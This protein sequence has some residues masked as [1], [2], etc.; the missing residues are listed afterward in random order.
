MGAKPPT[1]VL[2]SF[3]WCLT[4]D[5]N[6]VSLPASPCR[7]VSTRV[8]ISSKKPERIARAF[9]WALVLRGVVVITPSML[10]SLFGRLARRLVL[11]VVIFALGVTTVTFRLW[12]G[13]H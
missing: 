3:S 10:A 2:L 13:L 11:L 5:L 9:L 1:G 12:E 4:T 8:F 7:G 6:D